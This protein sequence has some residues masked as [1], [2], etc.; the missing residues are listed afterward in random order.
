[1]QPNSLMLKPDDWV[2]NNPRLPV[3]IYRAVAADGGDTAVAIE[4]LFAD[5]GWTGLWRNGVYAYHHYHSG[6][7]EVLGIAAGNATLLLGGPNG[8]NGQEVVVSAGDVLVLPAGTGHCR[9]NASNDF[10]VIGAYPAGQ[11]ADICRQ[12]PT[13]AQVEH[14]AALPLPRTDPVFGKNGPLMGLWG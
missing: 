8:P 4:Q 9:L 2:P 6:A 13:R 5:N 12:A 10:L 1:M 14:M 11:H 3:L 7:H